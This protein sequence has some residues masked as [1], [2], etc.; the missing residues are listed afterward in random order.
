MRDDGW[1]KSGDGKHEVD[2]PW[3]CPGNDINSLSLGDG[4]RPWLN[5]K[6][7]GL[8]TLPPPVKLKRKKD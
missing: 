8:S 7:L 2:Q 4:G 1:G 5:Q 6:V 3:T